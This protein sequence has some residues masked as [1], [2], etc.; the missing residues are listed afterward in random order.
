MA[1]FDIRKR[2]FWCIIIVLRLTGKYD[3]AAFEIIMSF[4]DIEKCLSVR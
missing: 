1:H 4:I 2:I 3:V